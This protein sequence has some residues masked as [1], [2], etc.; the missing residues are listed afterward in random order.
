MGAT[1]V[2]RLPVQHIAD[3]ESMAELPWLIDGLWP[4]EGV[5]FLGGQPKSCKSW[6]AL[7][8]ALSVASG[9]PAL[10]EYAVSKSGPV[11]IF[12]AEDT[13]AMVRTR[14]AGLAAARGVDLD[15]VPLHLVLAGRLRL[16]EDAD[17][18]RLRDALEELSPSLLILDPFVR[19]S[20]ID[21]N[22]AQEVSRVLGYLRELQRCLH[23]AILVVHHVRKSAGSGGVALR[24]SGD[25]W[26]WSDTNLF[27]ARKRGRLELALEHRSAAAPDPIAVELVEDARDGPYLR[28]VESRSGA[29]DDEL[30]LNERVLSL[31]ANRDQPVGAQALREAMRVRMQSIVDVMRDL[32]QTG[33]A[34]RGD[35]G[36]WSLVRD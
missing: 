14:L 28:R 17:Q 2:T 20:A 29:S 32:E 8:L 10:G 23:L 19:L 16:E 3:V 6:L 25:F 21:E 27:L 5:G 24:G 13:P 22:S 36:G 18:R 35:G 11:L 7:D 9:T 1:P 33:R 12:A 31:L 34:T 4:V 30:P 26:A 15:T